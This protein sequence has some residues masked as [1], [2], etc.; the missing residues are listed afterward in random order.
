VLDAIERYRW[1]VVVLLAVPLI[2]AIGWLLRERW[3]DP[4]PLVIQTSDIP[5]A[6]VEVYVAGAVVHPGV[7]PLDAGSRWIDALDAAGGPTGD[8]DLTAINL[9][10]R[11]ADEDQIVVPSRKTAVAGESRTPAAIVNLNTADQKTIEQLPGI[12]ETRAQAI[13]HSRE[14]DGDFQQPEDIVL[15]DLI[16]ASVFEDIAALVTVR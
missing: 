3:S 11:A 15:R 10:K 9:A 6:Q 13:I 4:D 7:Y 8:A 5:A 1:L 16:P 14:T 12:G 2:F